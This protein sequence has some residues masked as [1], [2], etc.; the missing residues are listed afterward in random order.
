MIEVYVQ[1]NVPTERME[2]GGEETFVV[3]IAFSFA[4]IRPCWCWNILLSTSIHFDSVF[5]AEGGGQS[6][7]TSNRIYFTPV[8]FTPVNTTHYDFL[9]FFE[10]N[11]ITSG[12][13]HEREVSF[14]TWKFEILLN[15]I[16]NIMKY[17]NIY[18]I[19]RFL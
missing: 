4:P 17:I 7:C 6:L 3:A 9:P 11:F 16:I 1:T 19:N 14:S 5:E 2:W 13:E 10:S 12:N 18:I 8:K 15:I